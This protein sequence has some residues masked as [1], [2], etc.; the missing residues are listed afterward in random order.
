MDNR[1]QV[2]WVVLELTQLGEQHVDEGS[3]E[4]I[5]RQDLSLEDD[6]Q[7]FIPATTF[8]KNNKSVT[9]HLMQGYAFIASGLS[10]TTYFALEKKPY[11][12]QV[13]SKKTG[14]HKLR[15]LT[16]L[17]DKEIQVLKNQL[18]QLVS[19]EI[20]D[21]SYVRIVDGPKYKGLEGRIIDIDADNAAVHFQMRA[22]E[23]IATIPKIFLEVIEHDVE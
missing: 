21:K 16:V 18:K 19:A 10:E 17:P 22:W 20:E 12:A 13:L 3:L 9:L 1:D 14:P 8:N 15:T 7:I 2:T 5:L 11:V 4:R 23:C 6:F